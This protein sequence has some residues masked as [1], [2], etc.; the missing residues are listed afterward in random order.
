M[1]F[2][3]NSQFARFRTQIVFSTATI[4]LDTVS[5]A[6]ESLELFDEDVQTYHV[7]NKNLG[8]KRTHGAQAAPPPCLSSSDWVQ[9]SRRA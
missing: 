5:L 8:Q 7:E 3:K 1:K 4:Y 9:I 2:I 6:E